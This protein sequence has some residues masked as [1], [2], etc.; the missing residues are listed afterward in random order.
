[1]PTV[2]EKCGW[3]SSGFQLQKHFQTRIIDNV[4]PPDL[5]RSFPRRSDSLSCYSVE[6]VDSVCLMEDFENEG[7]T[8]MEQAAMAARLYCQSARKIKLKFEHHAGQSQTTRT[9]SL[10]SACNRIPK[11]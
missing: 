1:M 5:A 10:R 2:L 8:G 6:Q 3:V 9:W 4:P 11:A 7:S